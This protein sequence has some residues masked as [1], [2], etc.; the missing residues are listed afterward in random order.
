MLRILAAFHLVFQSLLYN[1]PEKA[2]IAVPKK[3]RLVLM[4]M[5]KAANLGWA[6]P[7]AGQEKTMSRP[8]AD[9]EQARSRLGA[10]Q[11]QCKPIP[12]G[13]LFCEGRG[14]EKSPYHFLIL[15]FPVDIV[16]CAISSLDA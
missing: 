4:I 11:E 10:G 6:G 15:K 2:A 12:T 7:G 5:L 3:S 16:K 14:F 1:L 9:Y 13:S 8:G